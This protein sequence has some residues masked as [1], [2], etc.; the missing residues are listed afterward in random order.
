MTS[1]TK[2]PAKEPGAPVPIELMK[3]ESTPSLEEISISD[4]NDSQSNKIDSP[5]K[6]PSYS[7]LLLASPY[8][9]QTEASI[10]EQYKAASRSLQF[11]MLFLTLSFSMSSSCIFMI[12]VRNLGL[13]YYSD[14]ELTQTTFVAMPAF[15]LMRFSIGAIIDKFGLRVV[16]Q[17]VTGVLI[18]SVLVFYLFMDTWWVFYLCFML[19]VGSDASMCTIV[20]IST[21]FIYD[22]EVG[23]RL[24]KYMHCSFAGCGVITILIHEN[25]VLQIFG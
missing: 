13:H 14:H 21:S 8:H 16:Y 18:V 7:E 6:T 25:T 15:C 5:H 24:Q 11:A 12:N 17:F 4:K 10:D 9:Q 23:K 20:T 22:H 1:L 2:L 19:L 3:F